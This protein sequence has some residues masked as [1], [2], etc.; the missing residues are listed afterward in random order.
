MLPRDCEAFF[1]YLHQRTNV[2]VAP[3]DADVSKIEPVS[4]FDVA[5]GKTLCLWNLGLLPSLER[6]WIPDPGYYRV[7]ILRQP[8]LEFTQCLLTT[9]EEKPALVQG[10]LFGDFDEYLGKPLEFE[11][12]FDALARWMRKN[13]E[14][15]PT[16]T[17]G[18]VGPAAYGLYKSG[19]FLLPQFLPPRSK[20]W[21]TEIGKQHR[22]VNTPRA[23]LRRTK[24]LAKRR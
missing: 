17:G 5:D 22:S 12:W 2:V 9:W 11:K 19:G 7:D 6:A 13:L 4:G 15:N 24:G 10:R 8:V 20:V 23:E 18:Y 14:K 3:R 1:K 21:L 16:A